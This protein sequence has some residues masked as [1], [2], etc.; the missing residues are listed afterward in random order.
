MLG[1]IFDIGDIF[2]EILC[3]LSVLANIIEGAVVAFV[4]VFIIS[5][6]GWLQLLAAV[7]P[8]MP[9]TPSGSAPEAVSWANWI[10]PIPAMVVVVSLLLT[11]WLTIIGIRA[12]LRLIGEF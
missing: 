4:N 6:G 10:I 2:S 1:S 9:P 3:L 12:A 7:L 8:G 11:L 5:I